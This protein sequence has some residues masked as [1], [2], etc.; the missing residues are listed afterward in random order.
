MIAS[1]RFGLSWVKKLVS[2]AIARSCRFCFERG[3]DRRVLIVE[4]RLRGSAL[5]RIVE[6]QDYYFDS[7]REKDRMAPTAGGR[8][9]GSALGLVG[10]N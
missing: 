1:D 7:V 9:R 10:W 4:G 6:S 5:G 8:P 2:F 3:R